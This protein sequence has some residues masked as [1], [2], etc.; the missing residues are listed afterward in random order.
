MHIFASY[1]EIEQ[2]MIQNRQTNFKTCSLVLQVLMLNSCLRS[3]NKIINRHFLGSHLLFEMH[4]TSRP[5]CSAYPGQT[6][7][8]LKKNVR[9]IS[10]T[11]TALVLCNMGHLA[12]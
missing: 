12:R 5:Q 11:A 7:A 4:L 8:E 2:I 3:T 1:R 9:F 10:G 6:S